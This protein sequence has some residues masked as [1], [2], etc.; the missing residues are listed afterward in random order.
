MDISVEECRTRLTGEKLIVAA[1]ERVHGCHE[2]AWDSPLAEL[3]GM[4]F[5][6]LRLLI[7]PTHL[8]SRKG[9]VLLLTS[10]HSP[11]LKYC[12]TPPVE[13]YTTLAEPIP[14]PAGC[15]RRFLLRE[16]GPEERRIGERDCSSALR[17]H[18]PL[19]DCHAGEGVIAIPTSYERNVEASSIWRT[20][21]SLPRHLTTV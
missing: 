20:S 12:I 1:L 6:P 3:V 11:V 5:D 7:I 14:S 9:Q 19:K 13:R 15:L 2:A 21:T 16:P 8:V 17:T 18:P 4:P 10:N